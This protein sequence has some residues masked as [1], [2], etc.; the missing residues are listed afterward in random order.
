[1]TGG[2]A[3]TVAVTGAAS[4]LGQV[5]STRLAGEPGIGRVVALDRSDP[6]CAG[7]TWQS[8]DPTDPGLAAA[9]DGIDTLVHL[10][11]SLDPSADRVSQRQ[12][13][14]R[15]AS[16][17]L[18]AAAA[19]GVRHVV[20]VTSAR[21]YGAHADNPVPI[22]EDAPLRAQP[23]NSVLGDLLEIERLVRRADRAYPQISVAVLRPALLVGPGLEHSAAGLLDGP[24][25]LA[26][27]GARPHWQ[28]CHVDDLAAAVV[29][30]VGERLAG[31]L[32]VGCDGW[33]EQVE[34]EQGLGRRRIEL[35]APIAFGTAARLHA[36]GVSTPP[37]ELGY[38]V[39]PWVVGS[40]RL[41]AEGWK[42]GYSNAEALAAYAESR[43]ALPARLRLD[44]RHA[45][46]AAGAAGAT[47]ALVGTAALVRRARRRRQGR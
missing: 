44:G 2:A 30:T 4:Q 45:A 39:Y 21:V 14:A 40:E 32:T 15:A 20:L 16:V 23:E 47:V 25:L 8:A 42:P 12:A 28:F 22:P 43:P 18:T 1:M 7:V 33:M 31:P 36:V 37:S 19:T 13:N 34:V 27:R 5:V 24:R 10:A 17:A 29:V 3:L 38:L 41:R 35:P 46:A 9:L 6:E 11:V 26:V